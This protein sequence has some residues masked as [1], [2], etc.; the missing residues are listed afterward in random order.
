MGKMYLQPRE[1]GEEMTKVRNCTICA[2]NSQ[3][4]EKRSKKRKR[5]TGPESEVHG[6][7]IEAAKTQDPSLAIAAYDR[8]VREGGALL[9]S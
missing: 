4:S 1:K 8:A 5:T 6:A 9:V 3:P 7:I 2:G